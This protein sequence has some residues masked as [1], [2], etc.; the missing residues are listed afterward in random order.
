[1]LTESQFIETNKEKWLE[2][3]KLLAR[4]DHDVDR[5]HDLFIQVSSDLSY[6]RTFYPNRSVRLYLNNLTQKVFDTLNRKTKK[7]EFRELVRFFG[8]TVPAEAWK[9]RKILILALAIFAASV[10]IGVVSSIHNPEFARIILGD[11]YINMTDANINSGD[12]MA[13]YKDDRQVDMFLGITINNIKVAFLAFVLGI[14]GSVGS[15]VVLMFN[16]IMVGTFQ[17]YFYSKGLFMTS[18]LTIWIHGTIEISAIIIAGAAGILLGKGLLFPKTYDRTTSIQIA[19]KKSL[20]ILLGTIPLF[21]LAG[22]L[23]SFV[24]GQTSL[25]IGVK[26]LIITGS[27]LL[28]LLA[29]VYLPFKKREKANSQPSDVDVEPDYVEPLRYQQYAYRSGSENFILAISQLRETFGKLLRIAVAPYILLFTFINWYHLN[30]S[31]IDYFA[32]EGGSLFTFELGGPGNFIFLLILLPMLLFQMSTY[33]GDRKS[34]FDFQTFRLKFPRYILTSLPIVCTFYFFGVFVGLLFLL[35]LSVQFIV[36]ISNEIV[37][38]RRISFPKLKEMYI[39]SLSR[40]FKFLISLMIC[41]LISF[42]IY[43]LLNSSLAKI[44]TDL[45]SWHQLFGDQSLRVLFTRNLI[46]LTAF[47]LIFPLMY[48]FI[49]NQIYSERCQNAAIDL[50]DRLSAFGV[51]K[52]YQ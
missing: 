1:M 17:Y 31:N 36:S 33:F 34:G 22:I 48:F 44:F 10:V 12:P 50:Q 19:T 9:S 49:S 51:K 41:V 30:V 45:I 21:I 8:D 37:T 35:L 14:L 26:V 15:V 20:R 27:V 46:H 28:I 38:S 47:L 16:G 18:F 40:Y 6:A 2:L 11:A 24:T 52:D 25:P 5:L 4:K 29:W 3:E 32:Y 7:V 43:S 39:F 13:V 23:E 42:L